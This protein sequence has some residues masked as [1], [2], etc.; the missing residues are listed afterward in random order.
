MMNKR[1]SYN[2]LLEKPDGEKGLL[3]RRLAR[4][5]KDNI[6]MDGQLFGM[7]VWTGFI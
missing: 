1:N 5:R 7:R 3:L 6:K 2:I 4:S